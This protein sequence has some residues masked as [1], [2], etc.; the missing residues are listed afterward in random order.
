MIIN[1]LFG[2]EVITQTCKICGETKPIFEFGEHHRV[3]DNGIVHDTRCKRCKSD[4]SRLVKRLR[5]SAP[6]QPNVCDCCGK[7]TTKFDLDHCHDTGEFR[8]WLCGP[9]NKS[10]GHFGDSIAGLMMAIRYLKRFEQR[11]NG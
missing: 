1:T 2:E 7:P 6:P 3:S 9:C 4:Q 11:N 5:E 10:L 8:G